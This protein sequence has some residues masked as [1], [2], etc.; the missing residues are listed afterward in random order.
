VRRLLLGFIL[1]ASPGCETRGASCAFTVS[2]NELSSR[3]PTVGVIEWSLAGLPPSSAKIVYT[4][5]DAATAILNRGGEAPV[6]LDRPN[7]RT[8]LLGLKPTSDYTFRI[9]AVRDGQTCVSPDYALPRTGRF[10]SVPPVTVNVSRAA[11]R[12]AGFI[13]TSS[14]TSVPDRAFIIDADGEIVW[15]VGGPVST[16]RALMDYEGDNMWMIALNVL[17]EGGEM[18]TVSMDGEREQRDVPGL[19]FAH[20]DFTVMPGGKVAALVWRMPGVE[21]ESELVIRSPDGTV[22]SPFTIGGNLYRSDSFHAN[23]VHYVPSDGGFTIADRN[24]SVL[25]KVS[26]TGTPRW[27]LGGGC[28]EAP[29]GADHCSAQAWQIVHGHHLLDDGTLVLFNNGGD[30]TPAHVFAYAVD[31]APDAF[32]ATIVKSYAGHASSVTLG[33]VQRLPGGNT[34]VTYSTD[35]VI[36]ELDPSWNEVQRFSVRVGY[37]SWRPTLYGAPP[38][39]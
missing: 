33:D 34:L 20:H 17:N 18:R 3:I 27:Q 9:E 19:E 39:P 26:A 31:D 6:H 2:R 13:V 37:S 38:R 7:R 4:L 32:T 22:T 21:V 29:A 1:L 5:Q 35:G 28:E 24:P 23:A 25:V 11:A 30:D 8:L 12:E 36:V 16:T 15:T 14:G 10:A